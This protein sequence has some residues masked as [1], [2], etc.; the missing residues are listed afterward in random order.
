MSRAQTLTVVLLSILALGLLP[1]EAAARC[2]DGEVVTTTM[3]N[4]CTSRKV[5]VG[6]GYQSEGCD[7]TGTGTCTGC[8]GR[9]GVGACTAS[10]EV[11]GCNVGPELCNNCDDNGDGAID[12]SWS[13]SNIVPLSESCNPNACSQAGTRTCISGAWTACSGCGGTAACLGCG[14]KSGTR[15]CASNCSAAPLCNVGA[16]TCNNCDD[17]GDGLVDESLTRNA[18]TSQAGCGGI[19]TCASGQYVCRFQAGTRR[20]CMELASNCPGSTAECRADG[21]S[22]PCQPATAGPEV[23]NSCD[24]DLDGIVDNAP[25]GAFGSVTRPC[26]NSVGACPGVHQVCELRA[27]NGGAWLDNRWG[28][29]VGPPE[30]CNGED[31]DCD[32]GIDE[33]DVCRLESSPACVIPAD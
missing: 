4:G 29:C 14:N 23:C 17:D 6:G 25:G 5:C 18:C 27:S 31:D 1:R 3:A 7:A 22:G 33:G 19:E 11:T 9:A 26:S 13:G 32:D 2:T 20:S 16:E 12:N 24:D 15:A 8:G 21:S 30:T 28:I 10:C